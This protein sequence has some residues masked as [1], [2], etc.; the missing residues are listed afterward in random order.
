MVCGTAMS[1]IASIK[2]YLEVLPLL[3]KNI[4]VS[5]GK[6]LNLRVRAVERAGGINY[7]SHL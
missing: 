5:E 2:Y 1:G 7:I 6:K 4:K 3:L